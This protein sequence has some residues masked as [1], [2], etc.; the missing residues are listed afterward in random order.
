MICGTSD[1]FGG[2]LLGWCG[3]EG[4]DLGSFGWGEK[5]GTGFGIAGKCFRFWPLSAMAL[6]GS[7]SAL[8]IKMV[9]GALEELADGSMNE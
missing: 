4:F 9:I 7:G 2:N 3:L 1:H 8:V 6:L 5:K